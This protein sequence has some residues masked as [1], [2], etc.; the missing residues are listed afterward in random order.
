MWPVLKELNML[1][2]L[3]PKAIIK[4]EWGLW[5]AKILCLIVA[6]IFFVF[7]LLVKMFS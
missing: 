4:V 2:Q 7:C 6:L 1:Q 3:F 5:F